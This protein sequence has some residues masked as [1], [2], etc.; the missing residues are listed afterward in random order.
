MYISFR[1]L[2]VVS[3]GLYI[4]YKLHF[5]YVFHVLEI[6]NMWLFLLYW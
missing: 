4:V 3:W 5:L 6:S 1:L 2:S